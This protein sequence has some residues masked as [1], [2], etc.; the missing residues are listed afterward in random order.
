MS[1]TAISNSESQYMDGAGSGRFFRIPQTPFTYKFLDVYS[2]NA[3]DYIVDSNNIERNSENGNPASGISYWCPINNGQTASLTFKFTFAQPTTSIYLNAGGTNSGTIATYNFGN[4]ETGSGSLW[5]STNGADWI[6]LG[7]AP[8][9]TGTTAGLDY[10]QYLP[11]S[12]TGATEIWFQIQL[13][14]SG[15]A[16]HGSIPSPRYFME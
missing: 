14:T 13:E 11:S 12:L 16:Y 1:F 2:S 6:L 7:T 10:N 4:G 5:T 15:G 9:P 8:V 3:L